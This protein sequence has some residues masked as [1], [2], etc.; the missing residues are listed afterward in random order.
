ME[1]G[2]GDEDPHSQ[3]K[4]ARAPFF[5]LQREKGVGGREPTSRNT[6]LN[7]QQIRTSE[8]SERSRKPREPL[9]MQGY[10]RQHKATQG[11]K[12]KAPPTD[13]VFPT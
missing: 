4:R 5:R 7:R 1:K 12:L 8:K 3:N 2:T 11:A 9:A 13:H 10:T 6:S